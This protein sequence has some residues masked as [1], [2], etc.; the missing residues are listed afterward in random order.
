MLK[1]TKKKSDV[2]RIS[3]SAEV[4]GNFNKK[5]A[6]VPK[7]IEKTDE[8]KNAI[9]ER[10][11]QAFMFSALDDKEKDIVINAMEECN[12]STDDTVIKQGDDGAV[13]YLVFSGSL[14]CYRRM[15]KTDEE[16]TYLKT[17][18][19][20]EAFGELALLYNAPR[21]A[22]IIA[23]EDSVCYSLDRDCFNNIVKDSTV[24]RRER[25][26][27]FV[28][29]IEILQELDSYERGKITDVLTTGKYQDGDKVITEGEVGNKFYFIEE[30]N[31]KAIKDGQTVLE[32]KE[33]E[34]FGELALLNDEPRAASI[35]AVG[36]LKVAWI[37]QFAFKRL[38]GP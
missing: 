4:Y 20:G 17:Y 15:S 33:N 28:S 16:D 13:L 29:K 1:P 11:G 36:N 3:V 32:Y 38:L 12:F 19:P 24:K 31:A 2:A 34:Y 9:R 21:A 26:E 22:T 27:E 18:E 25:F 6:Y 35:V 5:A 7:V 14:K 30:G 37:D 10:L 23:A 8:A